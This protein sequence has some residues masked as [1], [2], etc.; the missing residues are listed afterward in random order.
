[1]NN[2]AWH[3]FQ[4]VK[5]LCR[6]L[7]LTRDKGIILTPNNEH[8][9]N[10]YVDSDFAGLWSRDT[11]NLRQSALS[12]AGYIITYA[13]CPIH[14]VSKLESEIALS[15]CEAEYIALS[16]CMR[17]LI[18]MRRLLH[19]VSKNFD[20]SSYVS[21]TLLDGPTHAVTR[22]YQSLVFEDNTACLEL[23]SNPEQHRPRTKHISL[24]W[25]HFL[26]QVKSRAI[27]VTKIDTAVQPADLLTK[28]LPRSQFEILRKILMG[29]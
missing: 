3:H 9:L 27:K 2:P 8:R 20:L 15:T 17:D 6:Y 11:A 5:Y 22:Q 18:P 13:G 7:L 12:R 19:E 23:A 1:V 29:W 26:D 28:P 16:M 21:T 10:A 24:K 14:W 25:H 4:A